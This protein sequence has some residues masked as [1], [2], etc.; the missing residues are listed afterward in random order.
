MVKNYL[1]QFGDYE[2]ELLHGD[3]IYRRK[4]HG[5]G[6]LETVRTRSVK[7][8]FTWYDLVEEAKQHATRMNISHRSIITGSQS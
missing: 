4:N 3:I 5:T 7:S 6:L 2:M 8:N 1:L